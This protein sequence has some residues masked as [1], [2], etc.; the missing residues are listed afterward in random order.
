MIDR[1][2]AVAMRAHG[3]KVDKAGEP[4]I[5]HAIRVGMA[6]ED[7]TEWIVGFLHD[8]V[9][10]GGVTE[11]ELRAIFS[12]EIVDAVMVLTRSDGEQ[13]ADYIERV[14]T[15]KL[16]RRVKI[17][18]LRDHLAPERVAAIPESLV[19]RYG[20]ALQRLRWVTAMGSTAPHPDWSSGV[21]LKGEHAQ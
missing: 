6:G 9:E 20:A 17:E 2:L 16:A 1:A 3:G 14:A 15:N 7:M 18:D 11:A 12:D 8:T 10:D 21:R 5:L 13:Y 4:M 19:R